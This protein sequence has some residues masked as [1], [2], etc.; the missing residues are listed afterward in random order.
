MRAGAGPKLQPLSLSLV[1]AGGVEPLTEPAA[2]GEPTPLPAALFGAPAEVELPP[3][4]V[5][6]LALV[7]PPLALVEPPLVLVAPPLVLV[8]PL[9]PAVPLFAPPEP[10]GIAPA[11]P[12]ALSAVSESTA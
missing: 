6:P 11:G 5:V 7:E 2:L 10:P 1:V 3:T 9:A 12:R 4:L 8:A